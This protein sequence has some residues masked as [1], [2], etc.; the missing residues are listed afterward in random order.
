MEGVLRNG[1]KRSV[2]V[3]LSEENNRTRV[4]GNMPRLY[5]RWPREHGTYLIPLLSSGAGS[6]PP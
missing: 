6:P 3:Q 1:K 4:N 5:K 2:F